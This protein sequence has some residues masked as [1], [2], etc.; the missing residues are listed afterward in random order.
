MIYRIEYPR[1][2]RFFSVPCCA[3]EN[4]MTQADGDHCKVLLCLLCSDG[5]TA[6]TAELAARAGVSETAAEDA[7]IFWTGRG[8]ISALREG[9]ENAVTAALPVSAPVMQPSAVSKTAAAPPKQAAAARPPRAKTVIRYSPKELAEKAKGSPE[10]AG[11]FDSVQM[12][13]GRPVTGTETAGLINIYEYYGF[14][15]ASIL[16]LTQF[17]HDLG[18]DR[19]AYIET[20]ANDWFSRGITDYEDVEREIGRMTE[21]NK[22]DSRIKTALGIE[23]KTTARQS[24]LFRQWNE[25]G[26]DADTVGL[27]G[28]HCRNKKSM[29]DLNYINGILRR[30]HEAGL[31]SVR[32]VLESEKRFA[33]NKAKNTVPAED[34]NSG[35]SSLNV[36]KLYD[37][38]ESFDPWAELDGEGESSK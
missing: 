20:V 12:I 26:F 38:A 7:L 10:I 2:G 5:N 27:A 15:A 24:E 22:Y 14:S 3:V 17:A 28:E 16:I 36:D 19:I 30:W 35:S 4:F 6:D 25:W 18:K 21:Q 37:L 11:L 9:S 31:M 29:N 32:A 1:F 33:E 34:A 8:I 23:G 13:L